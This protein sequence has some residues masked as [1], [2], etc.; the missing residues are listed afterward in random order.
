MDDTLELAR[1]LKTLDVD[2]IDCSMGGI[3]KDVGTDRRSAYAYQ[4]EFAGVIRREVGIKTNAVGLIVHAHHAEHIIATGLADT[5]AIARE[6]LYNPNWAID[7]AHK[8]G[9]DPEFEALPDRQRFW[10]HY[11]NRGMTDFLPSTHSVGSIA[12]LTELE[13]V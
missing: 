6:A 8:L 12:G 3:A 10:F 1:V 11:R 7:A 9:A 4:A 5:V 2:M 13:T